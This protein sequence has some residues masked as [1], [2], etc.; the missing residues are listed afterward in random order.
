[1][2]DSHRAAFSVSIGAMLETFGQQSTTPLLLGYWIGLNDLTIEQVQL[3][4]SN[5]IRSCR[6][7]PKPIE[8]RDLAVGATDLESLAMRAWDDALSAISKGPYRH[9]DFEDKTINAVVRS[10]G[11]WPSFVSRFTDS[12]GEKWVRI[13][14]IKCYRSF[15]GR[16]SEE[17][18]APLV[19]LNQFE[20][21]SPDKKPVPIR[22]RCNDVSRLGIEYRESGSVL[23]IAE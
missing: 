7:V 14:F 17:A 8:I 20:S 6:F 13:E 4:V 22:I 18:A 15:V 3:G 2:D 19:G 1:M 12:D 11:G 23:R 21:S 5:A 16:V 9:I 10:L